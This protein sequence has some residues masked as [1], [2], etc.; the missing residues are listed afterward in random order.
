MMV[1]MKMNYPEPQFASLTQHADYRAATGIGRCEWSLL[2]SIPT[3][4]VFLIYNKQWFADLSDPFWFIF[5]LAWL[6]TVTLMSSV[7]IVRHAEDLAET[8]RA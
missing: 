1:S 4:V 3:T 2:L 5:L 7:A 6:F 8:E